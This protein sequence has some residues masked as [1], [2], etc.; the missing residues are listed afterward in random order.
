MRLPENGSAGNPYEHELGW[1][2]LKFANVQD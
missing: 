2:C 1:N